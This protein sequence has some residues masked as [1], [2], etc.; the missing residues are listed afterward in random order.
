MAKAEADKATEAVEQARLRLRE[1]L[2]KHKGERSEETGEEEEVDERIM[3]NI[4]IRE[5]EEVVLRDV[6]NRIHD[7]GRWPLIV[8]DSTQAPVFFRYADSNFVDLWVL[9]DLDV[10]RRALL[11]GIRYGKP[12]VCHLRDVL[13]MEDVVAKFE[14]IQAGLWDSLLD[15]SLLESDNFF[16]LLRDTDGDEY[17]KQNFRRDRLHHFK[18]IVL[19]TADVP[20]AAAAAVSGP[21]AASSSSSAKASGDSGDAS[22]EADK[23]GD[24]L[25]DR[26]YAI[27]VVP[28]GPK[29]D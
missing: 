3:A 5:M 14:S 11:G 27:H 22:E 15:K 20:T 17:S 4:S 25:L 29:F 19:T 8:D 13:L 6:G 24:C 26:F 21:A 28:T 23:A 16:A 2:R 9:Q 18:F 10:M 12:V 1:Q 7:D